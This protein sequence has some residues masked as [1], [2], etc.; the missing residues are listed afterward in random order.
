MTTYYH[1]RVRCTGA[2]NTY[3]Y[4]I[5]TNNTVPTTC[6][7]NDSH[8][9]NVTTDPPKLEKTVV[10]NTITVNEGELTDSGKFNLTYTGGA[11]DSGVGVVTTFTKKWDHP[12]GAL[13][14]SF[15]VTSAMKGDTLAMFFNKFKNI[16]AISSSV[17]IPTVWSAQNYTEGQ[18]VTYT[19]AGDDYTYT[20]I[21]NTV[22]NE[23]PRSP[24]T[25]LVNSTYW[26]K[27]LRITLQ[28][29]QI[30]LVNDGYMA[31]LWDGVNSSYLGT[32]WYV[33]SVNNYIYVGNK[34]TD[35]TPLT[36]TYS[37]GTTY[38]LT[39]YQWVGDIVDGPFVLNEAWHKSYGDDKI[40]AATIPEECVVSIEYT[41]TDGASG[42]QFIG[43]VEVLTGSSPHQLNI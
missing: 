28:P 5:K 42:K 29:A 3:V 16:G 30:L 32:I 37:A 14:F 36:Q 20:C 24:T 31:K 27:G 25:G 4:G 7:L 11:V 40:G 9:I 1:W 12:V 10:P 26:R 21:T 35:D 41:N 8:T 22:S 34:H 38:F 18:T 33:D 19:F 23:A 2:H 13:K 15:D 6:F 43:E 39:G 17:S